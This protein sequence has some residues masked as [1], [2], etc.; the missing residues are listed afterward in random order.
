MPPCDPGPVPNT[1]VKKIIISL[2]TRVDL[3]VKDIWQHLQDAALKQYGKVRHL[4]G[5]AIMNAAA[6]VPVGDDRQ[7][8][9]F[10]QVS[11]KI[12]F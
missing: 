8:A 7:D 3:P 2:S 10:V 4:N 1:L 5:G 9:T 11:F 12:W 6:L